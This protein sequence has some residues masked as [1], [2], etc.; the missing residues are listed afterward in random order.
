M[1]CVYQKYCL[2]AVSGITIS[3]LMS[4]LIGLRTAAIAAVIA[5]MESDAGRVPGSGPRSTIYQ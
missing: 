3:D 4:K 5:G 2:N 1:C